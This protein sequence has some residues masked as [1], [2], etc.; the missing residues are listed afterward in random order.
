[1][2][3]KWVITFIFFIAAIATVIVCARSGAFHFEAGK[4]SA[5]DDDQLIAE[6]ENAGENAGGEG[7]AVEQY[8]VFVTAGNGGTANP[9]G[10]VTVASWD[11]ISMSFTP[12]EGYEVESVT[13][14]GEELGAIDEYTLSYI[15]ENHTIVVT[16]DK[17]TESEESKG[18]LL[19]N[20]FGGKTEDKPET[21]PEASSE[22]K[23]E[24]KP[25]ASPEA[26]PETKPEEVSGSSPEEK[27]VES[28]AGMIG[29][30]IGGIT[31]ET[32]R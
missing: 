24:T 1:M 7:E 29:K 3:V 26:K 10:S 20:L 13:L 30:L 16:F 2:G 23:P 32:Q 5:N 14:D 12:D 17:I 19:E 22:A 6:S 9:S 8:T 27:F 11:S 18:G 15:N 25:E 31:S 28:V 4:I 21:K